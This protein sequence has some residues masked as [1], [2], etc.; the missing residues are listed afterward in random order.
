MVVD[1]DEM[2]V[3]KYKDVGINS[4]K[5]HVKSTGQSFYIPKKNKDFIRV[6]AP[7]IKQ[8]SYIVNKVS[9]GELRYDDFEDIVASYDYYLRYTK[10]TPIYFTRNW[11]QTKFKDKGAFLGVIEHKS[12]SLFAIT[13]SDVSDNLVARGTYSSFFPL[14]KNGSFEWYHPSGDLRKQGDFFNN[15]P[16]GMFTTYYPGGQKYQEYTSGSKGRMYSAIWDKTGSLVL[17]RAT[18]KHTLYDSVNGRKINQS[19]LDGM[20]VHC[21]YQ[22]VPAKKVYQKYGNIS[23]VKKPFIKYMNE[24]WE[25][26]QEALREGIQGSLLVRLL[27]DE[28]GSL[29]SA[30]VVKG[31][32][33]AIDEHVISTLKSYKFAIAK[34]LRVGGKK[35]KQEVLLPVS[36]SIGS[37]FLR[38][39]YFYY[40]NF[41][42][43]QWMMHQQTMFQHINPPSPP[44]GF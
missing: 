6:V 14:R 26:P 19:Y 3:L 34:P 43:H 36:F 13:Y 9:T 27:I 44:P 4:F 11:N 10:G 8:Y 29:D 1:N 24:Q 2:T 23:R 21:H 18:G 41:F 22:S 7:L 17:E 16:K 12:D 40:E 33:P 37:D 28:S 39:R 30:D 32:H 20:L 35:F 31:L 5:V 38:Q 15:E 25:Y 42:Q